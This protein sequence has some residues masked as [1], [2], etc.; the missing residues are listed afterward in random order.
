M[1]EL[2]QRARNILEEAKRADTPSVA[3]KHRI[4]AKLIARLGAGALASGAVI[5]SSA[6]SAASGA[7]AASST[8]AS[9]GFGAVTGAAGLTGTGTAVGLTTKISLISAIVGAVGVGVVTAPW[10]AITGSSSKTTGASVDRSE[11]LTSQTA[12]SVAKPQQPVMDDSAA[13][14]RKNTPSKSSNEGTPQPIRAETADVNNVTPHLEAEIELL[15]AAQVA[16]QKGDSRRA[17]SALN[18]HRRLFPGGMLRQEREAARAV[19]LCE[20]GRYDQGRQVAKRLLVDSPRSPLAQRIA[21][22][23]NR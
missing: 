8:S 5:G 20:L 7:G 15:R 16:L 3:D 19:A 22:S 18:K 11:R 1:T 13:T 10:D 6:S 14:T 4:R 23:C 21:R 17:L 2:S 9:G 12:A